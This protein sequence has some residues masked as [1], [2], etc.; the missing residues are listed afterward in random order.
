MTGPGVRR[1]LL[2]QRDFAAL[3]WG[4]LISLLGERLSYLAL[5]GL[6]AEHTHHFADHDSPVLLAILANVMA[7]PVL[8]FAPFTG[9]WVDRWN[10]RRVLIISDLLRAALVGL[11]PMLY[12]RGHSMA[13]L[14]GMVFALFTCNV[15]F[16]PTKS[17]ITPEI[18]PAPQLLAANALLALAGVLATS[19]GAPLG[20]WMV[21]H[22]GW[23]SVFPINAA[24]YLASVVSLWLVT[25]RPHAHHGGAPR[26][27]W[28]TY[29]NEVGEGWHL[30]R[31][32]AT[33]GLAL[34]VLAAVWVGGGFLN[35]AGN[36]H[37]QRATNTPGMER[38]G[39]LLLVL[40]VGSAMGTWWVNRFGPAW[41][42]RRLLGGSLLVV[43]AG[44]ATF[45][46]SGR[47]LVFSGAALLIGLAA[48]PAFTLSETLL[49]EGTEARQRGRVFSARDFLMRLVFLLGG[50]AAG[51]LTRWAGTRAALLACA[52]LVAV[53][54]L[55]ALLWRR[56]PEAGQGLGDRPPDRAPSDL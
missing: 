42:H 22:W 16:T 6:L 13:A 56:L 50:T 9:A 47:Y 49:Q 53:A 45:A 10:L 2:R 4:Q 35:A 29:L 37:I 33:V 26:I 38:V 55:A 41:P 40:G 46:L 12:A 11:V 32:N 17:A 36:P 5:L 30:V 7:A 19:I 54:G 51:F 20:G 34:T 23:E 21:D 14:Y 52:G 43:S 1:P 31:R 15:F 8:L 44:L 48:A 24:T 25:Y 27:S 3:W 28:R 18:V 39:V